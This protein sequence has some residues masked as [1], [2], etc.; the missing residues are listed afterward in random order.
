MP[1]KGKNGTVNFRWYQDQEAKWSIVHRV[2]EIQTE[3]G[4]V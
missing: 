4:N 1:S 3:P 2:Q